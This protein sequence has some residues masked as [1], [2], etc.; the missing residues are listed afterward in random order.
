MDHYQKV[1]SQGNLVKGQLEGKTAIITGAGG[2]IGFETARALVWLGARVVIAEINKEKGKAAAKELNKEFGQGSAL[3]IFTDVGQ[4][5][6]V[7]RLVKKTVKAFGEIDILINNATLA[8]I[9]AVHQ[10]G[11]RSWD[12]SYGVN[13]RGPVILITKILPSMLRRNSGSIV[14][15]PSSGAAPYMG[16]YEV[17]KTSQVELANTLAAELEETGVITYSIGPGIVKT[18]TAQK[19][20]EQIAPLYGKSV[21]A[22]YQMSEKLLLTA[23]EAGAGFAASVAL[24]EQYRGLEI[25]SIQALM[26]AGIDLSK[27]EDKNELLLSDPVLNEIKPLFAEIKQVFIQQLDDWQQRPIFERQWLNRDF[28]KQ[29]DATPESYRKVLTEFE[30]AIDAGA[31]S[32]DTLKKLPLEKIASYYRHQIELLKGYEKDKIKVLDNTAVINGWIKSIETLVEAIRQATKDNVFDD[33][34]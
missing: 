12:E 16:A 7:N 26:D 19:A 24:A 6:S 20:I 15:V 4:A 14:L 29:M 21:E 31:I 5:S 11:V 1:I 2:G 23:E 25:G 13:L 10:V 34:F 18:E 33:K 32:Q 22:F 9:G 3:F 30:T 27:K 28:K 8:P 17:F